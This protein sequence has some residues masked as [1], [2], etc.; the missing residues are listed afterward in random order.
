LGLKAHL[1]IQICLLIWALLYDKIIETQTQKAEELAANGYKPPVTTQGPA[2]T[3]QPPAA[4]PAA[5]PPAGTDPKTTTP[6]AGPSIDKARAALLG[7]GDKGKEGGS[8]GTETTAEKQA[9]EAKELAAKLLGKTPA[10]P[11]KEEK[12]APQ[13]QPAAPAAQPKPQPPVAAPKEEKPAPQPQPAAPAAQPKPQPPVAAPKEEKPAPQPQPAA[14]AATKEEKP[15]PAPAA[16]WTPPEGVDESNVTMDSLFKLLNRDAPDDEANEQSGIS[17][18]K[19]IYDHVIEAAA[20]IDKVL[21]GFDDCCYKF[22]D[23]DIDDQ[24]IKR[25]YPAVKVKCGNKFDGRD[26]ATVDALKKAM[27]EENI[28]AGKVEYLKKNAGTDTAKLDSD[29]ATAAGLAPPAGSDVSKKAS[30]AEQPGNAGSAVET[31][32]QPKRTEEDIKKAQ[33]D[34]TVEKAYAAIPE[35]VKKKASADK[36]KAKI[37]DM[38]VNDWDKEEVQKLPSAQLYQVLA[39]LAYKDIT[40]NNTSA[41]LQLGSLAEI[42]EGLQSILTSKLTNASGDPIKQ[43]ETFLAKKKIR[44]CEDDFPDGWKDLMA[45]GN[46]ARVNDNIVAR[47]ANELLAAIAAGHTVDEFMQAFRE[48]LQEA[49]TSAERKKKDEEEREKAINAPAPPDLSE[50]PDG[51]G[52]EGGPKDE[53]ELAAIKAADEAMKETPNE[54]EIK[55]ALTNKQFDGGVT[56]MDFLT[57]KAYSGNKDLLFDKITELLTTNGNDKVQALATLIQQAEEL[58]A[59][60]GDEAFDWVPKKQG[61]VVKPEDDVKSQLFKKR[62]EHGMQAQPGEKLSHEKDV[63]YLEFLK[64]KMFNGDDPKLHAHVLDILLKSGG[65]VESTTNKLAA[66]A[67]EL[68]NQLGDK[69]FDGI[70]TAQEIPAE[71]GEVEDEDEDEV[72]IPQDSPEETEEIE[73]EKCSECGGTGK[74]QGC[75]CKICNGSGKKGEDACPACYGLGTDPAYDDDDDP[76]ECRLCSGS[77]LCGGCDGSGLSGV[78]D[79]EQ[80]EEEDDYDP[81]DE[82]EEAARIVKDAGRR[83]D[84]EESELDK[85]YKQAQANIASSA[86]CTYCKGRCTDPKDRNKDCPACEGDGGRDAQD[87]VRKSRGLTPG[88]DPYYKKD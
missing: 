60:L 41:L 11:P 59:K 35:G 12:P 19:K 7:G 17:K 62:F 23:G 48:K 27:L 13:P 64:K 5:Q 16:T 53:D 37:R 36:L 73:E 22:D 24:I 69:A 57:R 50:L 33:Q 26:P 74:C 2:A 8:G 51:L 14:P 49:Q 10:A 77:K 46:D 65:N 45:H 9:R 38:V 32:A 15:A 28:R 66:E 56:Y 68:R 44:D 61:P 29:V 63:S 86:A 20:K 75:C 80:D 82:E 72:E 85:E 4:Q 30:G 52:D 43:M 88:T 79:D 78:V 3:T 6:P 70:V 67:E 21:P 55:A 25:V 1:Q 31:P 58:K 81:S 54:K 18:F 76:K 39:Y 83:S 42:S 71:D 87:D 47:K 40:E 34:I 84:D